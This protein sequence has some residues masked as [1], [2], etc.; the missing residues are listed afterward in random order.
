MPDQVDSLLSLVAELQDEAER[1]R[2]IRAPEWA[3]ALWNQAL[4]SMRQ[5]QP[6][7]IMQDQGNPMSIPW[8]GGSSCRERSKWSIV[9]AWGAS[10]NHSLP[11]SL[12]Q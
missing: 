6:P 7:E 5:K 1:L 12:L 8:Q 9:Y 10:K 3:I 4:A 11:T 2:N